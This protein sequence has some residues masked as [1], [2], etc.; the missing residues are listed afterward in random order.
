M[1]VKT[2]VYAFS[3]TRMSCAEAAASATNAAAANAAKAKPT[4]AW[5]VI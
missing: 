4:H 3:I 5:N 1:F 2:A